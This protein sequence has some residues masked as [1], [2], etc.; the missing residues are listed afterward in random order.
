MGSRGPSR[1]PRRPRAIRAVRRRGG[2]RCRQDPDGLKA[3]QGLCPHQGAL[4]GEG[5]LDGDTLVCRNHRW[6]FATE[7]G[8]RSGGPECLA[9]CPVETRDGELWADVAALRPREQIAAARRTVGDLPGPRGLPLLG[10]ALQ[11]KSDISPMLVPGP[12]LP[13]TC[14]SPC[15]SVTNT[16]A[17]PDCMTQSSWLV[18]PS[19]IRVEPAGYRLCSSVRRRTWSSS[20]GI[21]S[22]KEAGI[23][24]LVGA[25]ILGRRGSAIT[26]GSAQPAR[27]R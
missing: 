20:A 27:A 14:S 13:T 25:T 22:N 21:P 26:S 7:T 6:R 24:R 1:G 23:D 16:S 19:A 4:L 3:Y 10:N 2:S 8:E 18:S 12:A 11:F 9:G 15:L 17:E 5:E